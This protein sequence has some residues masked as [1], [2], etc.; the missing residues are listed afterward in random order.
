MKQIVKGVIL[1][2]LLSTAPQAQSGFYDAYDYNHWLNEF[3]LMSWLP[4][5]T[6]TVSLNGHEY[7]A[8]LVFKELIRKVNWSLNLKY[9][10]RRDLWMIAWSGAFLKSFDLSDERDIESAL[11]LTDVTVGFMPVWERFYILLG[12]RYFNASVEVVDKTEEDIIKTNKS[13][14]WFDLFAGA[15]Y[16]VPITER[17]AVRLRGDVGGFGLGSNLSWNASALLCW[18]IAN[19]ALEAGYRAWSADYESS[20]GLF[21]YNVVTMGPGFGITFFF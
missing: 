13:R 8:D 21:K 15:R 7:D 5:Q 12:G 14:H 2:L 17:F 6:G 1:L 4:G 10:G 16:E 11:A 20:N 18:S 19:F 9:E 3:S